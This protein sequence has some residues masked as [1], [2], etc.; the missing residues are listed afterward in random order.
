M[1]MRIRLFRS[2]LAGA[3]LGVSACGQ[4]PTQP[5]GVVAVPV[6]VSADE[7]EVPTGDKTRIHRS[8]VV[9]AKDER[10]VDGGAFPFPDDSGGKALARS[11]TPRAP[12]SLPAA[13]VVTP[14]ERRLPA[15]L[16][17]PSPTLPDGTGT[18]PRLPMPVVK[19]TRP[20]PLPERVPSD[21]GGVMPQLPPRADLP[22]GPLTRQEGRD[23]SKPAELPILSNRPVTDRAPLTDP[24]LEYTA[25]SAISPTLPLRTQPTG[26]VR[27][28]LPDPFEHVDA[29]K[30]RTP[31]IDDPNR[32]LG[33]P[34]PPR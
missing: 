16:N 22:I 30:P 6:T 19:E 5:E 7:P 21:L 29:A 28:N 33:S 17:T 31:V 32:A 13:V 10:V 27:I 26:F 1:R 18:L 20:A 3:A 25:Q 11:L 9:P 34:P 24:T 23:V 15:Y 12:A 14:R 2:V 4:S 8:L